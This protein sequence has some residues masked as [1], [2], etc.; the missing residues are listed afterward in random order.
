MGLFEWGLLAAAT[1]IVVGAIILWRRGN[2]EESK[3][4]KLPIEEFPV[5]KTPTKKPRKSRKKTK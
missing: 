4:I 2:P 3:M 1:G 5:K